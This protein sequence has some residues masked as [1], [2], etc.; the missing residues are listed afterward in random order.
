MMGSVPFDGTIELDWS[1]RTS[2]NESCIRSTYP[3]V[4]CFVV[5]YIIGLASIH[6]LSRLSEVCNEYVGEGKEAS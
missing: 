5:L 6:V 2:K 4:D 1:I 3:A